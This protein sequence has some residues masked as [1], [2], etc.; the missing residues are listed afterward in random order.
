MAEKKGLQKAKRMGLVALEGNEVKWQRQ[1]N[2]EALEFPRTR[3]CRD[4]RMW[5]MG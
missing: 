4:T 1:N 3:I 5:R 2:A